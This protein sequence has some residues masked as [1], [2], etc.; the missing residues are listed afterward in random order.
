MQPKQNNT[1]IDHKR[2]FFEASKINSEFKQ[3][4]NQKNRDIKSDYTLY[5]G[6]FIVNE[7]YA[8]YNV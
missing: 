4:M 6:Y 7:P 8:Q 1:F 3:D 2:I 5:V